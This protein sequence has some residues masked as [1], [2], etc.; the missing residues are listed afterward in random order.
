MMKISPQNIPSLENSVSI[1]RQQAE[2][3]LI[4][5]DSVFQLTCLEKF[6]N[7]FVNTVKWCLGDCPVANEA[8]LKTIFEHLHP[9]S[10]READF[11]CFLTAADKLIQTAPTE[12][13][14]KFYF[15]L[16]VKEEQQERPEMLFC[17]NGHC[18]SKLSLERYQYCLL[19]ERY[20][21]PID[22]QKDLY[23]IKKE[24]NISSECQE[25]CHFYKIVFHANEEI[26]D[27]VSLLKRENDPSNAMFIA[28]ILAKTSSSS[29]RALRQFAA[30]PS[31]PITQHEF[32]LIALTA[33]LKNYTDHIDKS[34]LSS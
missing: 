23:H 15:E 5:D 34:R 9:D 17:H 20:L 4:K 14:N 31:P 32:T 18:I 7:Y 33:N 29:P 22:C 21:E 3:F 12:E 13:K 26:R 27:M 16:P 2:K 24:F 6:I 30:L 11:S 25:V 28:P 10:T 19:K 8:Q 1:S